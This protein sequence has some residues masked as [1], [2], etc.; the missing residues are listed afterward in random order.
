M[1]AHRD[2]TS[3]S[4]AAALA[5]Q[6]SGRLPIPV[7][8]LWLCALAGLAVYTMSWYVPSLAQLGK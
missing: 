1:E 2:D 7:M 4:N 5:I 6:P 8:L 3:N